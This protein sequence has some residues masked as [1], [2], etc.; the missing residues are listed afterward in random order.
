VSVYDQDESKKG[1]LG[2]LRRQRKKYE[3]KPQGPKGERQCKEA[4]SSV[5]EKSEHHPTNIKISKSKEVEEDH[6]NSL[7]DGSGTG[8]V[9]RGF[10]FGL[11]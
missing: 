4:G 11:V 5:T 1:A 6:C 2:Q 10:G 8:G 9:G 3:E 7:M